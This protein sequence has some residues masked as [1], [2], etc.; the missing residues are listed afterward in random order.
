MKKFI[1]TL[2]IT[3]I[4]TFSVLSA[5]NTFTGEF[6]FEGL[7]RDYRIYVPALYNPANPVPLVINMH[8]FG[9]NNVEQE[10]YGSFY[11]IADTANFL[12]LLPNGTLNASNQR[13]FNCFQ[14]PG[15]GIDDIGYINALLDTISAKYNVNPDRIYSTG[16]SNGGFMSYDLACNLSSRITAIASVTGSMIESHLA[17]CQPSHPMPV[18]E[19]HGTA[20]ATVPYTGGTAAT[21]VPIPDLVDFWANFNHCTTPAVITAVPNISTGDN[22]TAEKQVFL[23]G[24]NGTTVEH[25]KIIGGG[26]TWPGSFFTIGVTNG[27]IN[28]SV[29][30]WRFFRRYTLTQLTTAASEVS[31]EAFEA[32]IYPNPADQFLEIKFTNNVTQ[33]NIQVFDALGKSVFSESKNNDL[34]AKINLNTWKSGI[35]FV[36]IQEG[37]R[38]DSQR[39]IKN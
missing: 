8:G 14:A 9:S 6:T 27:D 26:H 18:M 5:Q 33:R 7:L 23:D 34:V 1:F 22:C 4:S 29:Q 17:A 37:N 2:F 24:D 35:Y 38:V 39:F 19:I 10:F 12:I 25:F 21:F 15:V 30:I 31:K 32:L 28:A 11:A 16:M 36:R 20:D 13:Y 3:L